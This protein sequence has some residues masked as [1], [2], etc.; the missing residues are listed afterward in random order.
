MKFL[1]WAIIGVGA[2][3]AVFLVLLIGARLYLDTDRARQQIQTTV[4]QTI[5][6]TMI[7]SGSRLSLWKG[8]VELHNVLLS[9]ST[10]D[11]L[12][13]L[14]RLFLRI[15]WNRFLNGE[16]CVKN[17]LFEA[18]RIYLKTDPRGNLNL[19]QALSSPEPK[20]STS[21]DSGLPFNVVIR[22]L[23]VLN[24]FFQYRTAEDM[25][26]S[27][28]DRMVLQ[29]IALTLKD[30]NLLEQEARLTSEITGG[31]IAGNRID[32]IHLSCDLTDRILTIND[33]N[34]DTVAGRFDLKGRV[35]FK[36]AFADGFISSHPDLN[37]IS[38]HLSLR[39]KDTVLETLPFIVSGVK[40]TMTCLMELKG[41]GVNPKTLTA[42]STLE[43]FASNLSAGETFPPFDAH[44]NAQA[45]MEKGRVTLHQLDAR[46]EE[47]HLKVAGNYDIASRK[48]AA[49]FKFNTPDL[50]GVLSLFGFKASG[51]MDIHS[52]IG[53]TITAPIAQAQL[54][55]ENLEFEKVKIGD[56]DAKIQFSQGMLSLDHGKIRNHNSL[57]DISGTVRIRDPITH[58]ILKNPGLDIAINGDALFIEDFVE[59]IQGKFTLNGH[60]S[61]D[62]AHPL[63][64]LNLKG[65]HVDVY[66]RKVQEV[67]LSSDFDG[68]RFNLD[69]FEIVIAPG[70][71]ILLHGWIS[72]NKNYHLR[73]ASEGISLKNLTPL[74]LGDGDTGKVSFRFQGQGG[75]ENP[76]IKGEVVL[77]ELRFNN[78]PLQDERFQIEVKD[79]TAY[80]SG[81]RNVALDATY[82]FQT[83]DFSASAGFD[84]TNLSPYLTI[85]GQSKLSGSITGKIQA[86]GNARS[87]DQIKGSATISGIEILSKK[88]LLLRANDV[89]AFLKDEE[90]S[91]SGVRL[92][93]FERGFLNLKG[94]CKLNGDLDINAHGTLP[95]EIIAHLSEGF[96][97]AAGD[98][99]FSLYMNGN[100]SHPYIRAD[101][102]IK[103]CGMTV[104]GLLQRM[105]DLNGRIR[106]TP[107]A[108]VIDNIR[109]MLD[110]G[111]FALLGAIDLKAFQPLRLDLK[112]KTH[113]LPLM[114]PD[115]LETRLNAELNIRG[116]PEKSVVSGDIQMIK[117]KYYKDMRLNLGEN[118]DKTS[119]EQALPASEIP[120]PFLKNMGLDITTRYKEPFIVDN[121]LALLAL[122]PD[123]RLYGSVNHPLISGRAQ[124]EYGTV[125]F[126]KKEFTVKKGVFDFIN[127]YKIEPA[128][129]VQSQIKIREWTVLLNIS[130]TPDNL[131]FTLSSDPWETQENILSL[132]IT[133]RTT[134]EL[135]SEEDG[136][137][138]SS[139]KI[140]ADILA[141]TAQKQIKDATGLDVV[142]LEYEEATDAEASDEVKV[143][144][145]KALSQRVTVK[146]GMQTKNARVIQQVI[147]E[148]K[149]L[150][151][152]L[153]NA[154]QDTEGH[155]GGGLQFRLE[156]R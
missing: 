90:I 143:T 111:R 150:E 115:T 11:K 123:L 5:S 114:I 79:R 63:G 127:P 22:E 2:V 142:E 31:N 57:L 99:L 80:I 39:Q 49:D 91:I 116:T 134:Q 109:G 33:L 128:I 59:G 89:Q 62:T 10:N 12:V 119:R 24:G 144:V 81:G 121:N 17:L 137:S 132:L 133:G 75:F 131:K 30:A 70:E 52:K 18:P 1:K 85:A 14:K 95:L 98:V 28:K 97:N 36:K 20:E 94:T 151:N 101:A 145:G 102:E 50:T 141:E 65:E 69:P 27:Q 77:N 125:Y 104:P 61:G 136:L 38:Y 105:H 21:V 26:K 60:I 92:D 153:I 8:E 37:A 58:D 48:I 51:N 88:T 107:E 40:G 82:Q 139:T 56:V 138:R 124:I 122:K 72:L 100:L 15:S 78:Q 68:D 76:Q 129:D 53:G 74:Q 140:L 86:T 106:I 43:L 155:Y 148:Y 103:N 3:I 156:F 55:G 67:R 66:T 47:T 87:P 23:N 126:Q 113:D 9:S 117:G 146:Y 41:T 35:D 25:G 7:W 84:N 118:L 108:V 32:R 112:L 42:E 46:A 154:F 152:I 135:I 44:V 19:V 83:Q 93:L 120:W 149:L 4:N 54:Q 13:E 73:L 147:T 45:N 71:T 64:R 16:L 6:G 110:S 34:L 29:N 96:P 130:G